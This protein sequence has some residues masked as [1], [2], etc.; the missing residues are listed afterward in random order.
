M[1]HGAHG[2]SGRLDES[3]RMQSK[4]LFTKGIKGYTWIYCMH[5]LELVEPYYKSTKQNKYLVILTMN[6]IE[7]SIMASCMCSRCNLML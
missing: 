3:Y 1:A 7:P 5:R 6:T 2:P 4:G